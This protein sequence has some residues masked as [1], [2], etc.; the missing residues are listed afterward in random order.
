MHTNITHVWDE[1]APSLTHQTQRRIQRFWPCLLQQ[2]KNANEALDNGDFSRANEILSDLW[3][4]PRGG[5]MINL[6]SVVD[7][8][9]EFGHVDTEATKNL[10]KAVERVT[11]SLWMVSITAKAIQAD[12]HDDSTVVLKNL[13]LDEGYAEQHIRIMRN[14]PEEHADYLILY[15]GCE[16]AGAAADTL[17]RLYVEL[18]LSGLQ[19]WSTSCDPR[20]VGAGSHPVA[21]GL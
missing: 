6:A 20:L 2:E 5:T 10:S 4:G 7:A 13:L 15:S 8:M 18:S 11:D 1:Y 14:D 21:I 3:M 12:P 17:R 16:S 19:I 9:E